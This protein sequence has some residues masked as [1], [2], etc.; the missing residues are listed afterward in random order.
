MDEVHNV[1]LCFRLTCIKLVQDTLEKS[2]RFDIF[3][4]LLVLLL[5]LVYI[6]YYCLMLDLSMQ[7]KL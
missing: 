3:N 4:D 5:F 7:W 6:L 1:T 2:W